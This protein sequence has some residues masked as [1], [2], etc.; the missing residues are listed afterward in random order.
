MTLGQIGQAL[1][2]MDA[3]RRDYLAA[4][5]PAHPQHAGAMIFVRAWHQ[6][7]ESTRRFMRQIAPYAFDDKGEIITKATR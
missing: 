4:L 2:D 5:D 1:I 3:E 6:A 7:N